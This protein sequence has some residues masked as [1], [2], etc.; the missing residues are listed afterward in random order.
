[1]RCVFHTLVTLKS[2][3]ASLIIQVLITEPE[4]QF[5][6]NKH[7][8]TVTDVSSAPA[9]VQNYPQKFP[10]CDTEYFLCLL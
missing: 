3:C 9:F 7:K 10:T 6:L 2:K 5:L 4:T 1:M 8:Q